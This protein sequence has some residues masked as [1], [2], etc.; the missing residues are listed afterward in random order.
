MISANRQQQEL[1]EKKG[2]SCLAWFIMQSDKHNVK[3][4]EDHS[5]K[6]RYFRQLVF[7]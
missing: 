5:K 7:T 6:L 2:Q 3:Y 1:G 4:F